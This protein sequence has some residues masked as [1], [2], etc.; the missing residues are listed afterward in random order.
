MAPTDVDIVIDSLEEG[1]LFLDKERHVITI[2][3]AALKMLGQK[4]AFNIKEDIINQL[5]PALFPGASC[6]KDCEQTGTCSLMNQDAEKEKVE[7]LSFKAL[8]GKKVTLQMRAIA[9]SSG[10]HLARIAILLTD[11]SHERQLEE[12]VK[13]VKARIR[14]LLESTGIVSSDST[15]L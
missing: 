4:K 11:C 3:Q 1:I 12:E 10:E 2:N 5:C 9:L 15:S 8:D 13:G 7:E 14:G 6:A